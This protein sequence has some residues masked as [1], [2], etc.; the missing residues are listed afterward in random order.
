MTK[1][2]ITDCFMN[3]KNEWEAMVV[4]GPFEDKVEADKYLISNPECSDIAVIAHGPDNCITGDNEKLYK[5][6]LAT[7]RENRQ[8]ERERRA[9]WLKKLE[10]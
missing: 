10:M 2:Y 3:E 8:R 1:A 6:N 5:K 7:W 9:E 4:A